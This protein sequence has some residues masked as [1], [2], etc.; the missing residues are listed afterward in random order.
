M[1]IFSSHSLKESN[2]EYFPKCWTTHLSEQDD[3]TP[4]VYHMFLH[5]FPVEDLSWAAAT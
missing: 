3:F 5:F 2:L 1:S 4:F